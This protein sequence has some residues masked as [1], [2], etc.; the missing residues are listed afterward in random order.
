VV[1]LVAPAV[2]LVAVAL[3][4]LGAAGTL[5][6]TAGQAHLLRLR[7]GLAGTTRAVISTIALLGTAFPIL[8][9][10][11]A[12]HFGLSAAIGL[13][14]LVPVLMLVAQVASG[15]RSSDV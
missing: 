12:D 7:P 10:T 3:L 5:Y 11:V 8:A 4:D 14:A 6:Y 9:G 13:Y 1:V 15:V 2:L